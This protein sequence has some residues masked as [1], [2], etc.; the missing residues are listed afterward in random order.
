MN[1]VARDRTYLCSV[2]YN[3]QAE[4]RVKHK[5]DVNDFRWSPTICFQTLFFN[6]LEERLVTGNVY[7]TKHELYR[8]NTFHVM[9]YSGR[10]A[11]K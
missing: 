8:V 9:H 6:D 2:F 4:S 1:V 3:F 5:T 10:Q 7:P 11:G